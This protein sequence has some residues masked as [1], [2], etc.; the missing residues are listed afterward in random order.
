MNISVVID[1]RDPDG[2]VEF[3]EAALSY[4]LAHSLDQF[5]VLTPGPGEPA[6]PV[7]ILQGVPETKTGKNRV[8]I[9]VH[10]P[11]VPA[12]L[13][14]L[15]GLGGGRIGSRV[16]A[17]GIWWQTISDPEGNE[18]CLVAHDETAPSPG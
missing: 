10:P 4:R 9:D 17:F 8:H 3:W 11:D 5:R 16:D 14:L 18:L 12:H 13:A 6:G 1:C 15:E 7:L 2:L